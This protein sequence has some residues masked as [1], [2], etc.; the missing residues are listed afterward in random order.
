MA[1]ELGKNV[2]CTTAEANRNNSPAHQCIIINQSSASWRYLSVLDFELENAG[3]FVIHFTFK[4][5]EHWVRH[6]HEVRV[7][8]M[9]KVG[10]A[11]YNKQS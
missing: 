10:I 7:A 3:H 2:G 8:K 5:D 9:G 6:L 11:L 1:P 4:Q